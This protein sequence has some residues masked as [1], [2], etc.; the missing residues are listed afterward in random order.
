LLDQV[1]DVTGF[2]DSLVRWA[3]ETSGGAEACG[4]TLERDGR[5][6]TVSYSGELALLGDEPQY[7]LNEGPCLQ[8]MRSREV[9][10]VSDMSE[11]RRWGRYPAQALAAGVRSSLS[12]PVAGGE[13]GRGAL[14][15]YSGR[16]RAFT[17]ADVQAGQ[18]W[19]GQACGALS[20]ARQMA[21]RQ[22]TVD[23]LSRGLVTR[24]V[25]GQAVGMVMVQRRCTAEEAFDLL[26]AA[27]QRGNEKLR[28]IAAR[29]IAGHEEQ[30]RS[31][32][33]PGPRPVR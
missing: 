24:Q 12:L 7:Q 31:A 30:I 13:H 17:D 20:L 16:P 11:E 23:N 6:E 4:L 21:E 29:M 18:S 15:L 28:D 14:N 25:I 22:A 1:E 2:L 27:S 3:V 9:V 19:A 8:A 33:R 26:T 32:R 5:G 10:V